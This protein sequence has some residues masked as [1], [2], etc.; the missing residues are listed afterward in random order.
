MSH[1]FEFIMEIMK[2]K[3]AEWK[4]HIVFPSN[5]DH[6]EVFFFFF[7]IGTV[8]SIIIK[9]YLKIILDY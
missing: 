6:C 5:R 9:L 7:L 8:K 1:K 4:T 2:S 3:L